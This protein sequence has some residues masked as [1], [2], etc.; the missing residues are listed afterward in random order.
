ML[1]DKIFKSWRLIK[2]CQ[3]VVIDV[4]AVKVFAKRYRQKIKIIPKVLEKEKAKYIVGDL[5]HNLNFFFLLRV[6]DFSLWLNRQYSYATLRDQLR[7]FWLEHQQLSAF[8]SLSLQNFRQLFKLTEPLAVSQQRLR[9]LKTSLRWLQQHYQSETLEL[10]EQNLR[11]TKFVFKLT[12]LKKFRDWYTINGSPVYSFKPNQL[13]YFECSLFLR[14]LEPYLPELTVFPDQRL[15]A[16]L[17]Y[18]G[19]LVYSRRLQEKIKHQ[20]ELRF[21]SRAEIELRLQT[22]RAGEMLAQQLNV[23]SWQVDQLLWLVLNKRDLPAHR[24]RTLF[25]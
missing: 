13:L 18:Y 9:L 24:T 21:G 8:M 6:L 4:E 3:D 11:P 1:K 7:T 2:V 25:Y 12:E 5:R 20:Q 10:F 22:I 19:I 14:E 17:N 15:P 23:P 16:M